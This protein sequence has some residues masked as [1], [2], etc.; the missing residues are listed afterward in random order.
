[1]SITSRICPYC[2]KL[3]A[4]ENSSCAYCQR[5]LPGELEH[6]ARSALAGLSPYAATTLFTVLS[7]AVYVALVL[8]GGGQ[9]FESVRPAAALRWGALVGSLGL[10]EPWRFL[11][12]MFVHFNLMHVAFNTLALHSMGRNVESS[13][14]WAR[15]TLLFLG[16]GVGGFVLSQL[17]YS[18]QPLTGGISGGIFGLLG[19][20]IGWRFAQGDPRWKRDAISGVGYAVVMMLLPALSA[21]NAAH[22]GGLVSGAALAWAFFRLRGNGRPGRKL[23]G[24]AALLI[25]LTFASIVL[26]LVSP[27]TRL[28]AISLAFH[29]PENGP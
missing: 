22:V 10:R 4:R 25:A 29:S 17:W 28:R 24:A 18:P 5:R 26:S 8:G 16:A 23:Q 7:L 19:A 2:G 12:A 1:V 15:F 27:H 9:L 3:N 13:L 14:G 20:A 6:R 21:N 11:S